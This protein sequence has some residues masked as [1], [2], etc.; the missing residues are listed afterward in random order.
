MYH[1]FLKE[2]ELDLYKIT[3]GN[4]QDYIGWLRN[5]YGTDKILSIMS[6]DPNQSAKTINHNI[7][8]VLSYYDYLYRIGMMDRN[9]KDKAT[10]YVRAIEPNYKGSLYHVTKGNPES[11]SIFKVKEHK[12]KLKVLTKDQVDLLYNATTNIRDKFLIRLLFETGMRIGEALYLYIED[13]KY[14]HGYL[15][16]LI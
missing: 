16:P 11:R 6:L 4:L 5:P 15:I 8:I 9:I 7:A 3:L 13:F 2:K 14:D 12:K 10:K 1:S